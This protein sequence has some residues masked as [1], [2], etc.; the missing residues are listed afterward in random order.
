M[1][2]RTHYTTLGLAKTASAAE[3]KA[4]Y[5]RMAMQWHPDRNPKSQSEATAR[6]KEIKHAYETLSNERKREAYDDSLNETRFGSGAGSF[7]FGAGASQSSG[8]AKPA[9]FGSYWHRS[10][11]PVRGE[12]IEC[13]ASISV[14]T[15][16]NGGT[17]EVKVPYVGPCDACG[18]TGW[19]RAA[20]RCKACAGEGCSKC[21]YSGRTNV[22]ATCKGSGH[23][24]AERK[25][26]TEV[27]GGI[28]DGMMIR[29]V[30]GGTPGG[31]GGADGDALCRIKVLKAGSYKLQGLDL[32]G[33]VKVDF[34]TAAIG[35]KVHVDVFGKSYT[36][37]VPPM[38]RAG[39]I[40]R[41]L[42][43]G[44]RHAVNHDTGDLRLRV[45][46]DLPKGRLSEAQK[47]VLRSMFADGMSLHD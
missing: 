28:V 4:A 20:S 7:G 26:A 16:V 33:E 35:G 12:D 15:A 14:E 17:I 18:G 46:I 19:A 42:G 31:N 40:L 2:S 25:I 43:K 9:G 34:A 41:L 27:R 47:Q 36:V 24:K 44:L 38:T 22:C 30:G 23:A 45:V 39:K 6:F 11:P 10:P 3:I 13:K 5:R 21:D 37:E 1:T 32:M 8:R 29:I